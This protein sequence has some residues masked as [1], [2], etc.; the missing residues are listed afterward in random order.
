MSKPNSQTPTNK[1]KREPP[2]REQL[3]KWASI[4]C[5]N[6]LEHGECDYGDRCYYKHDNVG[7]GAV[8]FDSKSHQ[9]VPPAQ[10][11]PRTITEI[12]QKIKASPNC[13]V[14]AK[15]VLDDPSSSA[16]S[17][18]LLYMAKKALKETLAVEE[19]DKS[20]LHTVLKDLSTKFEMFAKFSR[21]FQKNIDLIEQDDTTQGDIRSILSG[22]IE[23]L[24]L[25]SEVDSLFDQLAKSIESEHSFASA[26]RSDPLEIAKKKPDDIPSRELL[27]YLHSACGLSENGKFQEM[28]LACE[29]FG[30]SSPYKNKHFVQIH[31]LHEA[32][33][34][35]KTLLENKRLGEICQQQL[36]SAK[37]ELLRN[38]TTTASGSNMRL[39]FY[40]IKSIPEFSRFIEALSSEE[41]K[42]L[43]TVFGSFMTYLSQAHEKKGLSTEITEEFLTTTFKSFSRSRQVDGAS[44]EFKDKFF[45]DAKTVMFNELIQVL[46]TETYSFHLGKD[47]SHIKMSVQ[48]LLKSCLKE[49]LKMYSEQVPEENQNEFYRNLVR[50]LLPFM[51]L[52][53]LHP[54]KSN[55]LSG[56]WKKGHMKDGRLTGQHAFNE[57]ND[58]NAKK[59]ILYWLLEYINRVK[60][61]KSKKDVPLCDEFAKL[62]AQF[63]KRVSDDPKDDKT[64]FCPEMLF[65]ALDNILFESFL[66]SSDFGLGLKHIVP[67][68]LGAIFKIENES[69]SISDSFPDTL[70]MALYYSFGSDEGDSK[71]RRYSDVKTMFV[72]QAEYILKIVQLCQS[73]TKINGKETVEVLLSMLN[74]EKTKPL[75][76]AVLSFM[77]L[78]SENTTPDLLQRAYDV[79]SL[80]K[81]LEDI[82]GNTSYFLS[83]IDALLVVLLMDKYKNV[84]QLDI[85][86]AVYREKHIAEKADFKIAYAKLEAAC[87]TA[88]SDG[89][90]T[91]KFRRMRELLGKGITSNRDVL[92]EV[93]SVISI[94]SEILC[95]T[96]LR[97]DSFHEIFKRFLPFLLNKLSLIAL[98]KNV[99]EFELVS[100]ES[101]EIPVERMVERIQTL[102]DSELAKFITGQNEAIQR[103]LRMRISEIK[104]IQSLAERIKTLNFTKHISAIVNLLKCLFSYLGLSHTITYEGIMAEFPNTKDLSDPATRVTEHVMAVIGVRKLKKPSFLNKIEDLEKLE[105]HLDEAVKT[106]VVL[107]AKQIE[108]LDKYKL[109]LE[110]FKPIEHLVLTAISAIY[111][112]ELPK[113][114]V[115]KPKK[116]DTIKLSELKILLL[117]SS[118][119]YDLFNKCLPYWKS[120]LVREI[121]LSIVQHAYQAR[122]RHVKELFQQ[123]QLFAIQ[124]ETNE[125]KDLS[126][127]FVSLGESCDKALPKVATQYDKS[128][129]GLFE[130][131]ISS[132]ETD[133][134]T[135]DVAIEVSVKE[136]R[137][138]IRSSGGGAARVPEKLN[139][140]TLAQLLS[141]DNKSNAIAYMQECVLNE[142]ASQILVYLIETEDSTCEVALEALSQFFQLN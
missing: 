88:E 100:S 67:D 81:N 69:I 134:W 135:D 129:Q 127:M 142:D 113:N 99:P 84:K 110:N 94:I 16:E 37:A 126:E 15:K 102:F 18:Q 106:K 86:N 46:H 140:D 125:I 25:P 64:V 139:P 89:K 131:I 130:D 115:A 3:K 11:E 74:I 80:G 26:L 44:T 17:L 91:T 49:V 136:T 111:R 87:E 36:S 14:L 35:A 54:E 34:V 47:G 63:R 20:N 30:K 128:N 117:T 138:I 57:M 95:K 28:R 41:R 23:C 107:T 118:D 73:F 59:S 98:M 43:I 42:V 122:E 82:L 76:A 13:G 68:Q 55:M 72:V 45:K 61:Q 40:I 38:C 65:K 48:E 7:G 78:L 79:M 1:P 93:T 123:I 22:L 121:V 9:R 5:K 21:I 70:L 120:N 141:S 105:M 133:F 32:S 10:G 109:S 92:S 85:L 90:D 60:S 103:D 83:L 116:I 112:V 50:H 124:F 51:F 2:T 24:N 114:E 104:Q 119:L 96:V 8:A 53:S 27:E 62:S 12:F 137:A 101:E 31:E 71:T 108:R 132:F 6:M 58:P 77:T 97:E 56:R 29:S 52:I 33:K 4:P 39:A 75:E 19:I 66:T